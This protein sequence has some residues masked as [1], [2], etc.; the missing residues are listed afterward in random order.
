MKTFSR[1]L[2]HRS[3]PAA[4]ILAVGLFALSAQAAQPLANPPVPPVPVKQAAPEPDILD[5]R[6]PIHIPAPFPWLVWSAGAAA[7]AGLGFAAWKWLR[8]TKRKLPY[9][10]ALEKLEATRPLMENKSAEPFSIAVSEIVRLFIEECLPL[11]AAHR[12]TD[13]FLH[14]LV[15]LPESPLAAHREVMADFLEHC[16]LAKFACWS[17]TK[18]QMEAMLASARAFVLA[19]GNSEPATSPLHQTEPAPA[20]EPMPVA[21]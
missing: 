16:D 13:E 1:V 19:I 11:R 21:G 8:R 14:D 10:I 3:S 15:K 6:G 5:I 12:T 20:P 9:E 17:L 2:S 7:V 18:P 4:V